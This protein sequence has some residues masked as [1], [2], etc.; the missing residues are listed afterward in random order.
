[1]HEDMQSFTMPSAP[2]FDEVGEEATVV[3]M[4]VPT[5]VAETRVLSGAE[6]DAL[7]ASERVY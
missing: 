3:A 1:M 5:D 2:V 4:Q 6:L 7:L